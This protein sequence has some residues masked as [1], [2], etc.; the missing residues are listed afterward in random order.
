MSAPDDKKKQV[1]T[2]DP[3][4]CP[5]DDEL[6]RYRKELLSSERKTALEYHLSF[7]KQCAACLAL[8][9][10]SEVPAAVSMPAKLM[11]TINVA[12]QTIWRERQMREDT[13]P[14]VTKWLSR[15]ERAALAVFE[16]GKTY[17]SGTLIGPLRILTAA[18]ALALRG[19]AQAGTTATVFEVAVGGNVYGVAL[20]A[21][22][23]DFT[24]DIAGYK[25]VEILPA[26]VTI[27]STAGETLVTS[28]TDDYGNGRLIL[29]HEQHSQNPIVVI[30]ALGEDVW[31]A[32][33]IE[34]PNIQNGST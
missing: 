15:L 8:S 18:P 17:M 34:L 10:E 7:C 20:S 33:T 3:K 2:Y 6:M 1:F 12:A 21:Q 22:A 9:E 24:F 26:T 28:M 32:F 5:P 29:S 13:T 16:L 31:E 4:D 27:H 30:F 23:H 19:H 14:Q 11:D 25:C